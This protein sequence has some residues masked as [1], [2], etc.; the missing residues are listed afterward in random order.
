MPE[1]LQTGSCWRLVS[2]IRAVQA[3]QKV[4]EF[5]RSLAEIARQVDTFNFL[6]P[7]ILQNR[8]NQV[9]SLI[10]QRPLMS[11]LG[12]AHFDG[13][14]GGPYGRPGELFRAPVAFNDAPL[15]F[16]N[17]PAVASHGRHQEGFSSQCLELIH[18]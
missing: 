17:S 18:Q 9:I 10:Q 14:H 2:P 6:V 4:E 13:F 11:T 1:R 8:P 5:G 7:E 3:H 15:V 16:R 12:A